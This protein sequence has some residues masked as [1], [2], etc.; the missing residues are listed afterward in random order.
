MLL[1]HPLLLLSLLLRLELSELLSLLLRLELRH[2]LG[3]LLS[4]LELL[5]LELLRKQLKLDVLIVE[6]LMR[7]SNR[8]SVWRIKATHL[9]LDEL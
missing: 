4:L 2:L 9:K 1:A 3:L 5:A 6:T 7:I 8:A